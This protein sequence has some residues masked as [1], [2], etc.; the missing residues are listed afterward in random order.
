MSTDRL[1][2][3]EIFVRVVDAGTQLS[4]TLRVSASTCFSRIHVMPRGRIVLD[5]GSPS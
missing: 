5:F 4:G 3:M 1:A 2:A